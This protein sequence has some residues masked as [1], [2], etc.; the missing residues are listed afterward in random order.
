MN[1]FVFL[2]I[3]RCLRVS[4]ERGQSDVEEA[5]LPVID[6][7][8]SASPKILLRARYD[9]DGSLEASILEPDHDIG[10]FA[11][12]Q[13]HKRLILCSERADQGR[14]NDFCAGCLQTIK[15]TED[16]TPLFNLFL[17]LREYVLDNPIESVSAKRMSL[18]QNTP[19]EAAPLVSSL[20]DKGDC[21]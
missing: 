21:C 3:V 6:V 7:E 5:K 14:L 17:W 2:V 13:A 9:A 4:C 16:P 18:E 15:Q 20:V 8:C 1:K 12:Y 11:G 19:V 10:A